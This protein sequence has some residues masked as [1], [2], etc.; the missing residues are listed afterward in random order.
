MIS[1]KIHRSHRAVV[2]VCDENLLGKKFEQ[3]QFQLDLR[4]NFYKDKILNLEEAKSLMIQQKKEDA[5]FNIV[6][7]LST[8]AAMEAKII[9]Q[10]GIAKIQSVPFAL[11]L[12]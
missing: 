9:S 6:G 10:E 8:K 11:V 2:A 1:I 3:D 12:L 4:E 7:P 5:T